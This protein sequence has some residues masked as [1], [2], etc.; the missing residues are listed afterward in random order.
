MS[1]ILPIV[2]VGLIEREEERLV[3]VLFSGTS[4]N[5]DIKIMHNGAKFVA[6]DQRMAQHRQRPRRRG[7]AVGGGVAGAK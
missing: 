4:T 7:V 3:V 5:N 2:G 1:V 6:C